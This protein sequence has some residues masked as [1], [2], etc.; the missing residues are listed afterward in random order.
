MSGLPVFDGY[1]QS[2]GMRS[3]SR[4]C[5]GVNSLEVQVG[6][7]TESHGMWRTRGTRIAMTCAAASPITRSTP[8]STLEHLQQQLQEVFPK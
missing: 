4:T 8:Q 3:G 5:P 2:K 7:L 1:D 6:E